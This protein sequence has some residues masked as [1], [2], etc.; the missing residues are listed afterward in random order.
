[1][2]TPAGSSSLRILIVDDDDDQ[3]LLV[4]ELF[5]A[6][7]FG[8]LHEASD[9]NAAIEVT[10][11]EQPDLV[12]LDLA[13]PGRSGLEVLPDLRAAA[14]TARV[15]VLS[16]MPRWRLA[17]V[18]HRR[19]AIGYVEK[20]VPSS[21]L[22]RAILTAA[23]LTDRVDA[24]ASATLDGDLTAPREARRFLHSVLVDADAELVATAELLISEL[25]TN[26]VIHA[27]SSPRIDIHLDV[28]TVRVSVFDNDPEIPRPR[29]P[30][31]EPGGRG[32]LLVDRMAT[33]WG[34]DPAEDGKVVWFELD[35]PA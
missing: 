28:E 10:A 12:V 26:A 17:E 2:S 15:V 29:D 25:V 21:R 22:V 3:R 9:G 32:L 7:G 11:R 16:N 4:R 23:A 31:P 8:E 5:G 30:G 1:M 34:A 24:A 35:R 19:G 27:S 20:R 33:T 14:P 13:M 18:A 6:A